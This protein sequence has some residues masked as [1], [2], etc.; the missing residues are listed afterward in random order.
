MIAP[1][2]IVVSPFGGI[3]FGYGGYNPMGFG[4]GYGLGNGLGNEIRD[5]RQESE[6]QQSKA[7]LEQAKARE[8][9]LEARLKALENAQAAA[10]AAKQ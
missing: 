3:G 5:Y 9:E 4:L 10:N 1:P 7:E 8:A 2:P 6:I